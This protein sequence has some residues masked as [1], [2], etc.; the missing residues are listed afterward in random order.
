[1]SLLV[2]YQGSTLALASSSSRRGDGNQRKHW[3]RRLANAPVVPHLPAVREK[4]VAPLRGVHGTPPAH[5][6]EDVSVCLPGDFETSRDIHRGGILS[7]LVEHFDL[8]ARRSDEAARPPGVTGSND[9]FVR[10]H[11][12]PTRT[13]FARQFADALDRVFTEDN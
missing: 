5:A 7:H 3:L 6:D 9:T 4:E 1:M 12:S 2:S 10:D 8:Q 13:E 11:Q